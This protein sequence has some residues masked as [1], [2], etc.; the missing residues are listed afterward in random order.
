MLCLIS[1][2]FLTPGA[3]ACHKRSEMLEMGSWLAPG[4]SVTLEE[5][6]KV[7]DMLLRMRRRS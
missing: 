1:A 2:P 4:M 6:V 3:G 5:S 7:S